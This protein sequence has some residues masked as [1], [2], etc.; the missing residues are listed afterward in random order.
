MLGNTQTADTIPMIE[1]ESAFP[2]QCV[3]R[4]MPNHMRRAMHL[5][6]AFVRAAESGDYVLAAQLMNA[7]H[8]SAM[9]A[10]QQ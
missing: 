6:R 9:K 7:A 1:W 8:R 3:H 5:S 10:G 4:G 2:G